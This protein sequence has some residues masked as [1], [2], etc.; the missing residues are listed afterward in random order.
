[1]YFIPIKTHLFQNTIECDTTIK[2]L[3]LDQYD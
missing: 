2:P 1:M 3:I